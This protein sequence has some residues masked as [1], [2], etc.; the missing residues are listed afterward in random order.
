MVKPLTNVA[1]VPSEFL[2]VRFHGKATR[3]VRLK[4]QVIL[5]PPFRTAIFEALIGK[6]PP[7]LVSWTVAPVLK[8]VPDRLV[9]LTVPVFGPDDG[10]MEV[11]VGT[12]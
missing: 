7:P 2:T 10:E 5:V 1:L 4:T 3:L 6:A 12:G 8:F 11:I 9:M